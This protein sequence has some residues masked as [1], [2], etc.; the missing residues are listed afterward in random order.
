MLQSVVVSSGHPAAYDVLVGLHVLCAV[1]GFGAVAVSGAYGAI[2]RNVES[3]ASRRQSAEEVRRYFASPSS[4][5]NLIL[6]APLFGMGAM[7]VRPGGSQFGHLWAVS[8]VVIWIAAGGLLTAVVR[9]AERRIR[10]AG[11]D[12]TP[13]ANDA[14]R[15]MWAA[16]GSDVLFVVA[17]FLMVTQPG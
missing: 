8:G 13:V 4:L 16:A 9:P 6:I 1:V 17:L 12:L 2:A 3:G 5:E 7:A 14:R 10:S 15:L 11:D